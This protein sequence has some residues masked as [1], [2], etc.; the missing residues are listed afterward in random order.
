MKTPLILDIKG[1]SLDDGHGIRTVI[2]LKGCSMRCCWCHNPESQAP[3]AE[4]SVSPKDCIGCGDCRAVCPT[5]AASP[6]HVD[7]EACRKCFRCAQVCP[8][9]AYRIMGQERAMEEI[10]ERCLSDK[11][12][13]D[14]SGGGV[15]LSG[16]EPALYPDWC[17]ALAE[18][19]RAKGISV[20]LETAGNV[21]YDALSQM[22]PPLDAVYY[23]IKLMDPVLHRRYCG[24]DNGRILDN[25]RK[26]RQDA[27]EGRVTLLP[28]TPLIPGITDTEENLAAIAEFYRENGVRRCELLPYN[29]TWTGKAAALGREVP[30]E[31]Q[32]HTTPQ[33]GE[34]LRR[35]REIFLRAGIEC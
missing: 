20:L 9:R 8:A 27:A 3:E 24:T 22:L 14:A 10:V 1:N 6:G 12:F 18:Q 7:R 35:C 2:F 16:G 5:G 34:K 31:L 29:P 33:D 19:L 30:Y 4:L 21:P 13:Y 15:T 11:A 28:R 23:D 17:A 32:R 25:F 26:L